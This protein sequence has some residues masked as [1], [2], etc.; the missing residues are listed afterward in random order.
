MKSFISSVTAIFAVLAASTCCIGPLMAIAGMLG[1]SASQLIWLA[2]IKN[3]LIL[4]SLLL[5]SYNLY[6]AYFP[7]EEKKCCS[8]GQYEELSDLNE[9]E[10]QAVSF[11]Q[12]KTFLWSVAAVT[13]IILIL[14]YLSI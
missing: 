10:R 4:F 8:S 3:Y 13:L 6:R 2:S 7:G 9:K 11:F 12:S 14:P 5:I 1:V